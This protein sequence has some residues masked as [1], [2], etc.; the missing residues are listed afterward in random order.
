MD[1]Y[2][3]KID[4]DFQTNQT[5]L[6]TISYI[7]SFKG[8][9]NIVEK[10]ENK[11]LKELQKIATIESIGS[12][13]RIEG[14]TLSNDEIQDLLNN[15]KISK[16]KTRD[17]QEVIGY[18]NVL[19]LIYENYDKINLSKNYILQ[20]HQKLLQ[21]STKDERHR[22][23]YKNL[24]NKVVAKYPDGTQKILFNTT[25]PY[26]VDNEMTDLLSWS[27]RQFE[28]ELIHPLIIIA[29]FV[30]EFLSIHP[31][32][33]GNGRLSRLLTTF[34]LLKFDYQFIK[35]VSFENIIEQKKKSY[36]EVLMDG[37]KDR[38][39]ENEKI[40]KWIIFFLK[41]MESMIKIL[42]EKYDLYKSKGGYL[43]ERQKLIIDF[44]QNNQP[45]K[46]ADMMASISDVSIHTLKKDLQYMKSENLIEAIGKNKGT[47]YI[48]KD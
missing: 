17:Q 25:E 41:S 16:L 21:Y 37:Q 2:L 28:S 15:L 45:V 12:S 43:N 35:F 11:Y 23:K 26:L 48:M 13:T 36:Y 1:K 4:F 44:I 7:D 47:F 18:Y 39:S 5:I 14:A 30:Y 22:G 42:E 27:I 3:N 10:N 40:D 6:K 8:K 20:F 33:D 34:L 29:L 46:L 9:W 32:Q 31:F 38:N 19:E 24:S